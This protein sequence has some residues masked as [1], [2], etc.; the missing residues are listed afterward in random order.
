MSRTNSKARMVFDGRN[1]EGTPVKFDSASKQLRRAVLSCLLWEDQHYESGESI[2]KRIQQLA[3]AV[4]PAELAALAVEA[5]TKFNLR[6]VSLLLL[7]V[8]A[9]TARGRR[10]GLVRET[11]ANVIQRADEPAELVSMWLSSGQTNIPAQFKKGISKAFEK[12]DAY[13]LTKYN[14][15]QVVKM[16]D[17]I[18]LAHVKPTPAMAEVIAKLVNK[19]HYPLAT[20]SSKFPVAPLFGR[21]SKLEAPDTW[22]VNLSGGGDKKE[23]FERLLSERKLGYLAVL[24]NLRNMISAG[25]DYK[26][27][28]AALQD[29]RGAKKVF[30]FRFFAAAKHA[31]TMADEINQAF[32]ASVADLPKL[33]GKTVVIVDTSGSM[34]HTTVSEK[35]ELTR[36]DAGA[37]LAAIAREVCEQVSVYA[38][39]STT[40]PVPNLRGLAL[41]NKMHDMINETGGGGIYTKRCMDYVF[42]R[43]SNVDRVIIFTDEQDCGGG[44]SDSPSNA[45]I[46]GKHNYMINV[47]SYKA[48]ISYG[49]WTKIEG[50]SEA[51]VRYIQ[52]SEGLNVTENADVDFG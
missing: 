31:P 24:R 38:T 17:A 9:Q 2:A 20:K 34:Y 7:T 48:A 21:H 16:R 29:R 45:R 52:E 8:L 43:D 6:H 39:G 5:R 41:A 33:P 47:G 12:F 27:I 4:P 23:T 40:M 51:V 42:A 14:R 36:I 28:N 13:Q 26:L 19:E 22:E 11:V 37:A 35:S 46:I 15:P 1:H 50:F 49:A 3:H 10:D 32:L 25:V 44:G 30:P 18:F